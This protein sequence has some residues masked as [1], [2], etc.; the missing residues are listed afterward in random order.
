MV[1]R[2]KQSLCKCIVFFIV[3]TG[4]CFEQV[5]ADTFFECTILNPSETSLL[6][7]GETLEDAGIY[8]TESLG[9]PSV[10][11]QQAVRRLVNTRRVVKLSFAFLCVIAGWQLVSALFAAEYQEQF[12]KLCA[13]A[14]VV[15]YIH[16]SD[17]KKRI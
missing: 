6:E 11:V 12:P 17:G 7:G 5:K 4:M 3:M 16:S 9:M 2:C 14:V 13:G 10:G 15:D 8:T 1:N